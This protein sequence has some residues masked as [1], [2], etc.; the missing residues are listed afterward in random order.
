MRVAEAELGKRRQTDAPLILVFSAHRGA[1]IA[2]NPTNPAG[3]F[4]QCEA[5]AQFAARTGCVTFVS[6]RTRPMKASDQVVSAT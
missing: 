3:G 6:R 1:G 5:A 2:I 4:S